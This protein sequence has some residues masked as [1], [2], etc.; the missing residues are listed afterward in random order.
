MT[1]TMSLNNNGSSYIGH[2]YL[3]I[4]LFNLYSIIQKVFLLLG[5]EWPRITYIIA[6]LS[7]G[8]TVNRE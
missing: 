7:Q 3:T 2:V 4:E 5:V 8:V 6:P 1:D